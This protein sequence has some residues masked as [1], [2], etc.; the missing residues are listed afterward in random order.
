MIGL[1]NRGIRASEN[2]YRNF[3]ALLTFVV[4]ALAILTNLPLLFM[5]ALLFGAL[6]RTAVKKG[7]ENPSFVQRIPWL[8]SR[9]KED[10]ENKEEK[11]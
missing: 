1:W 2:F 9:K 11:D 8:V 7:W 5:A 4:F 6:S 10:K 3:F